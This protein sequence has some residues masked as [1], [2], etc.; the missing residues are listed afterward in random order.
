MCRIWYFR[1][2]DYVGN[3]HRFDFH[4]I[5]KNSQTE[6]FNLFTYNMSSSLKENYKKTINVEQL[7]RSHYLQSLTNFLLCVRHCEMKISLIGYALSYS[8]QYMVSQIH[9]SFWREKFC[10]ETCRDFFHVCKIL[11]QPTIH[12][13]QGF[14][15]VHSLF[16][17]RMSMK[18]TRIS[19]PSLKAN[20]VSPFI[21]KIIHLFQFSNLEG[22]L[23]QSTLVSYPYLDQ[24]PLRASTSSLIFFFLLS[25]CSFFHNMSSPFCQS[26]TKALQFWKNVPTNWIPNFSFL[27]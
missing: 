13:I 18:E 2:K 14:T 4:T 8:W 25:D 24:T 17:G 6:K 11:R 23:Y 27:L 16:L 10:K 5:I 22:F 20:W 1:N 26:N 7:D 19:I 12:V 9:P 15:C 21:P 3:I